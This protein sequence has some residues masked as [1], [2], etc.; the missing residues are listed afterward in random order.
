M[1]YTP[2]KGQAFLKGGKKGGSFGEKGSE[3]PKDKSKVGR[4]F[5][6]KGSDLE[7]GKHPSFLFS[8]LQISKF[9]TEKRNGPTG[10]QGNF[11]I[12]P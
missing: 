11:T 4:L 6:L 7:K 5:F 3:L 1:W 8:K 12:Y 9:V 10:S 2:E